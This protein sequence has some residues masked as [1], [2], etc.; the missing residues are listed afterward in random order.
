M[1]FSIISVNHAVAA[2]DDDDWDDWN[3]EEEHECGYACADYN[4]LEISEVQFEAP[5]ENEPCRV[6]IVFASSENPDEVEGID[7]DWANLFYIVDDNQK[8]KF[9]VPLECTGFKCT[10]TI[11][12]HKKGKKITFAIAAANKNGSLTTQGFHV[13]DNGLIE[14]ALIPEIKD[15]DIG[16][17]NFTKNTTFINNRIAFD[18]ERVFIEFQADYIN[19]TRMDPN[20]GQTKDFHFI[21]FGPTQKRE[22][23]SI[24]DDIYL[25]YSDRETTRHL[26]EIMNVERFVHK[27]FIEDITERQLLL[28]KITHML[29]D[30]ATAF[31]SLY[32]SAD[33]RIKTQNDNS[34]VVSLNRDIF[35][36]IGGK[37]FRLFAT[38]NPKFGDAFSPMLISGCRYH[39]FYFD[40]QSY[41]VK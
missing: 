5:V 13:P 8:H 20:T 10:G 14:T 32:E 22:S 21:Q 9:K 12:Q 15:I 35:D 38:K 31:R 24:S 18:D 29:S 41:I 3:E 26:L 27:E 30:D 40:N 33:P 2:S 6:T 1:Q 16:D 34:Y 23:L 17:K 4:Y 11:P 19:Q 25:F 7:I 37:T 28:F 36:E 39:V